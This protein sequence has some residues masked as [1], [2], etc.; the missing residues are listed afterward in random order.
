MKIIFSLVLIFLSFGSYA[1][2]D[3]STSINI[4][5]QSPEIKRLKAQ[6]EIALD[7]SI[8]AKAVFIIIQKEYFKLQDELVEQ[9]PEL[10][11]IRDSGYM[12]GLAKAKEEAINKSSKG[13]QVK[14]KFLAA[15]SAKDNAEYKFKQAVEEYTEALVKS[16]TQ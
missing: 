4:A 8:K 3:M 12:S 1:K 11:A 5:K 15:S 2:Q 6:L 16:A 10:R 13:R 14:A 9:D 7:E